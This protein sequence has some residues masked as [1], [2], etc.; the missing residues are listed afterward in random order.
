[1]VT[2]VNPPLAG[3]DLPCW[4]LEDLYPGHDSAELRQA[5]VEIKKGVKDFVERYREQVHI[6]TGPVFGEAIAEYERLDEIMARLVS[7]AELSAAEDVTDSTR[8]RFLQT[9]QEQVTLAS[10]EILFF[11]LE[12][13]RLK[14]TELTARLAVPA[15]TRYRS[16]LEQV[17][18]FRAHQ[19]SDEMER[20]LCERN[21]V[22]N[23]AWIRLFDE[24]LATLRFT[25]GEHTLTLT[26]VLDRL[27]DPDRDS[28]RTAAKAIGK[29]LGD[30]ARLF[31]RILNTL[32]KEKEIDDRWRQYPHPLIYRNLTNQIEDEIVEALVTAV[33][34]SYQHLTHRYYTFKARWLGLERLEYWDRS[35]PLLQWSE[36]RYTWYEARDLV[37]VAYQAFSPEL[38]AIGERFFDHPWIDAQI[39]PGKVSGAFAH[40]TVPSAHPYLL[41]NYMGKVRDVM[42]LAHELGHGIHQSLAAKQGHL[43]SDT[44]L[45]MAETAS[46]FGEMLT[47]QALLETEADPVQRRLLL[48]AKIED[49]LSTVVRQIAFLTF[50][51]LVH[52]ERRKEEL[53]VEDIGHLWMQVQR[54][55]LGPAFHFDDE[56]S[57]YWAYISHFVHTPFY[58]Y[59]YAFGECLVNT[60]YAVYKEGMADFQVKYIN[61]LRAGGTRRHKVLLAPFGLDA[62]DPAF[63]QRGLAIISGL[64]DE[65]E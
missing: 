40:P 6:L 39:R 54:E 29:G 18:A 42:T 58:V 9:I 19:L 62:S 35:A 3:V 64:I 13:N 10:S 33:K 17:R 14:E 5:L 50:E 37:L 60:L 4:S 55:S 61:L 21:V 59:A 46:M 8:S 26:E 41:L 11:T 65:L 53:S 44:A 16:W 27:S 43:L 63:W 30:N 32:V 34:E 23:A 45:T 38:A 12:I 56:Y 51:R 7:Y 49:M 57:L 1:M 15:V 20:V 22:G 2:N 25:I 28:R 48:A 52:A 24:T 47:F 36:R 31:T